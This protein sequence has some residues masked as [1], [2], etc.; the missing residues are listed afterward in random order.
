MGSRRMVFLILSGSM[1]ENGSMVQ[2]PNSRWNV[3][4]RTSKVKSRL[5]VSTLERWNVK[6]QKGFDLDFYAERIG[7]LELF[8]NING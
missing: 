1:E 5:N 6:G 2:S 7:A 3:E 8:L 4:S